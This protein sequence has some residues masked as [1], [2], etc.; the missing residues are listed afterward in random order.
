MIHIKNK[1]PG[2]KS[3]CPLCHSQPLI[4]GKINY[5]ELLCHLVSNHLPLHCRT[6][7]EFFETCDDLK[8]IGNCS[9]KPLICIQPPT[10]IESEKSTLNI[11]TQSPVINTTVNPLIDTKGYTIVDD[12]NS[13]YKYLT[14][15]PEFTRN[16][17]TPMQIDFNKQSSNIIAKDRCAIPYFYI[18]TPSFSS[19]NENTIDN[20]S[21]KTPKYSLS[22]TESMYHSLSSLGKSVSSDR[23]PI[24]PILLI[25]SSSEE[26]DQQ[27]ISKSFSQRKLTAMQEL[28]EYEVDMELTDVQGKILTEMVKT[29]IEEILT[30]RRDSKDSRKKVRFSD[31][32][33]IKLESDANISSP[34]LHN[35]TET[36]EF[37]EAHQSFSEM[38]VI[39]KENRF[40]SANNSNK[41]IFQLAQQ[42]KDIT[43]LL[44][45]EEKIESSTSRIIMILVEN[46][47]NENPASLTPLIN[48]GL[49]QLES[50]MSQSTKPNTFALNNKENTTGGFSIISVD[51]YTKV[52]TLEYSKVSE[53]IPE[54]CQQNIT[55]QNTNSGGGGI[56]TAVANAVKNAFKNLSGNIIY[57]LIINYE[58]QINI[59]K[60]DI[61]K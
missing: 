31:Q 3:L 6:C 45:K 24:R 11:E 18:K 56:F 2:G 16:T 30:S 8:T 7:G 4:I 32:F 41:D 17:S 61:T 13:S 43:G 47:S 54:R 19:R 38:P 40:E 59:E 51:S 58:K 48:S 44:K 14:S 23:T 34:N 12:R 57:N 33:A 53:N 22:E 9:N 20:S 26:F 5:P 28:N 42:T 36:E 35:D 39:A 15:P 55:E 46:N 1:H 25:K 52:S 27:E 37:F 60:N 29:P 50:A 49:K 10:F 21:I